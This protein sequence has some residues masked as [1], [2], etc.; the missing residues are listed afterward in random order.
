MG[1]HM[2]SPHLG[3]HLIPYQ[4]AALLTTREVPESSALAVPPSE[5]TEAPPQSEDTAQAS[6]TLP[7][8][9]KKSP[10]LLSPLLFFLTIVIRL[11]C[12]FV[13]NGMKNVLE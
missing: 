5:L 8:F 12:K 1:V 13:G 6:D 3:P 9:I 7:R 2:Q 10:I 11:T 4:R